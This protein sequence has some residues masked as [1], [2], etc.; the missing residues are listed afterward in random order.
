[1][2]TI[3]KLLKMDAGKIEAPHR[4]VPLKLQKLGGEEIV[5]ECRAI[6]PERLG[7]LQEQAVEF[8]KKGQF[9]GTR[10]SAVKFLIILEA[11]PIFRN[12][13]VMKHFNAVTPKELMKKLLLAGELDDLYKEINELNGYE[14]EKDEEEQNEIKNL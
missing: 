7:E 8:S 10:M 14:P 9:K 12:S 2:N 6:D 5:F 4:N 13:D 1:M 11:C 3:E